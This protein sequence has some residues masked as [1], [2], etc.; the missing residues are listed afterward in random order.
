MSKK[1]AVKAKIKKQ[2]Q[3]QIIEKYTNVVMKAQETIDQKIENITNPNQY[4][5]TILQLSKFVVPQSTAKEEVQEKSQ[6]RF[7]LSED[8][9]III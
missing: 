7:L 4:V 9:Q 1:A 6:I 3:S 2:K 8:D 5:R